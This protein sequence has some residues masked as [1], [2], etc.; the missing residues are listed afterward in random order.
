MVAEGLV[1]EGPPINDDRTLARVPEA[2]EELLRSTNGFI[3]LRGGLHIRGA[4]TA[5]AWH[6]LAAAW[7][8][9]N[10]IHEL[11]PAV[12]IA[13]VPFAE[14][15]VGDQFILRAG[16]VLKL[17]AELGELFQV[18]EDLQGF[19]ELA[20]ARPGELIATGALESDAGESLEPGWLLHV[21][22]P[23]CLEA[24]ADRSARAIEALELRDWHASLA[25]ELSELPDGSTVKFTVKE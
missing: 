1:Y 12:S 22:P 14:D 5:P 16:V 6:S 17:D 9:P 23:Y 19:W 18:S 20:R 15:C 24:G 21:L 7:E 4:C 8:G 11:Y 2:L 13:D 10:A 3:A 25:K